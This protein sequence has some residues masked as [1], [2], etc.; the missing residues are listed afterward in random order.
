MNDL[1]SA[2]NRFN[3]FEHEFVKKKNNTI[4]EAPLLRRIVY[5]YL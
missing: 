4:Y 2:F 3:A 1:R 5:A